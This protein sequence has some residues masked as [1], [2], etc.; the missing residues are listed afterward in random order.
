MHY[1]SCLPYITAIT[2]F[3]SGCGSFSTSTSSA[4]D[5]DYVY[6]LDDLTTDGW[7]AYQFDE[8]TNAYTP[9]ATDSELSVIAE[10]MRVAPGDEA[11][12]WIAYEDHKYRGAVPAIENV[13][14]R[15]LLVAQSDEI[16]TEPKPFIVV[17]RK[18]ISTEI[19]Y[20][21]QDVTALT[22]SG[23]EPN[24][25]RFIQKI[26]LPSG[27]MAVVAE[28]DYEPRSLGSYS[29]RLYRVR[30]AEAPFDDF[31][32]GIIRPRPNGSIKEVTL[33]DID[34]DSH[35]D[36]IVVIFRSVGTGSFLSAEAFALDWNGLALVAS[37][38]DLRRDADLVAALRRAHRE[39]S[40]D[41]A[42][43]VAPQ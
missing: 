38:Q 34:G 11:S 12:F 27:V 41:T 30:S 33:A 3:T 40:E 13:A 43:P 10:G 16:Q 1:S 28:G 19:A 20:A 31:V 25:N 2:L 17:L 21:D 9:L 14:W 29:V 7:S 22:S 39:T 23:D 4:N 26:I 18:T 36:D 5:P 32:T 8:V 37:V 6:S 35:D 24:P 15:P 42:E